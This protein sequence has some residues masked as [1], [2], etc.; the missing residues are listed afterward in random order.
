MKFYSELT[1][2]LYSTQSELVQEEAKYIEEQ[3][4]AKTK[5]QEIQKAYEEMVAAQKKYFKLLKENKPQND[6]LINF[7]C[8]HIF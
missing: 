4:N 1:N 7:L 3:E 6:S 2:K 5:E 8:E